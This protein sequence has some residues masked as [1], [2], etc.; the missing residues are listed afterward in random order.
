MSKITKSNLKIIY[1]TYNKIY[2]MNPERLDIV[3]LIENNPITK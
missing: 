1:I 2:N 3:Q